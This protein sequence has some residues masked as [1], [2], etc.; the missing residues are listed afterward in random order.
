[1]ETA[2]WVSRVELRENGIRDEARVVGPKRDAVRAAREG[3]G[4]GALELLN[5]FFFPLVAV[6]VLVQAPDRCRC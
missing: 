3:K 6:G 5:T 2:P 1:M 4:A